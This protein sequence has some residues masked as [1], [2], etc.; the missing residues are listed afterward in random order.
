MPAKAADGTWTIPVHAWLKAQGTAFIKP[1]R[2]FT[3]FTDADKVDENKSASVLCDDAWTIWLESTGARIEGREYRMAFDQDLPAGTELT[4]TLI[5]T[6]NKYYHYTGPAATNEV[7]FS[8]FTAMG[9]LSGSAPSTAAIDVDSEEFLISADF[10][11]A[12]AA[13]VTDVHVTFTLIT[14]G[15]TVDLGDAS[16]VSYSL[17]GTSTGEITHT[18]PNTIAVVTPPAGDQDFVAA[19]NRVYLIAVLNK[20]GAPLVTRDAEAS[21]T[22]AGETAING[23]QV[24]SNAFAFDLAAYG[25]LAAMSG[26]YAFD[27]L[28]SGDYTVDWML[29]AGTDANNCLNCIVSNVIDDTALT[30][31]PAA[32]PSLAVAVPGRIAY[33]LGADPQSLTFTMT[34]E[35]VSFDDIKVKVQ[36]Q[37][38]LAAFA[39]VSEIDPDADEVSIPIG[40]LEKGT[41]RVVFSFDAD[42][43]NDNVYFSFII[44]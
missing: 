44:E 36:K 43:V 20:T 25:S 12:D 9:T 6:M 22:P 29:C 13:A 17:S 26:T 41:Y 1:H 31:D 14:G 4:L 15:I 3:N 27:G 33:E 8:S 34:Y 21:F 37:T 28:D 42:S 39:D 16:K 5:G 2:L 7:S 18:A 35:N 10:E 38:A 32:Q 30:V 19:G 40:S 11:N 23:V 24:G